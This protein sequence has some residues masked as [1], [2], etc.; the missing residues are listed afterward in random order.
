MCN[1]CGAGMVSPIRYT[2]ALNFCSLLKSLRGWVYVFYIGHR[3]DY[4]TL[5]HVV[6]LIKHYHHHINQHP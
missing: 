4:E 2:N 5:F 6:I 1:R 3:Q